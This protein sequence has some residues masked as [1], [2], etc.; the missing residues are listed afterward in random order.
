MSQIATDGSNCYGGTMRLTKNWIGYLIE[1]V[2]SSGYRLGTSHTTPDGPMVVAGT[3]PGQ[4]QLT[5]D[6][7][8]PADGFTALEVLSSEPVTPV[9]FPSRSEQRR[10]AAVKDEPLPTFPDPGSN[11]PAT[12]KRGKRK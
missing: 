6:G 8:L 1:E 4:V 2:D 11:V 12:H 9:E 3:A 5:P 7:L 10:L